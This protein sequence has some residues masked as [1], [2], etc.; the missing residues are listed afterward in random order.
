LSS[1]DCNIANNIECLG[2]S[3]GAKPNKAITRIKIVELNRVTVEPTI[4]S[5]TMVRNNQLLCDDS[6][7]DRILVLIMALYNMFVVIQGIIMN[8]RRVVVSPTLKLTSA[9]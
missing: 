2:I 5:T 6:D 1:S 9:K 3:L 8:G 4:G 7:N